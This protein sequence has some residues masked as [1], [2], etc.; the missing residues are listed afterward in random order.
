[1]LWAVNFMEVFLS[2]GNLESYIDFCSLALPCELQMKKQGLPIIDA[3]IFITS[4][5]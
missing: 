5:V 2:Q 3:A 4:L 1:M